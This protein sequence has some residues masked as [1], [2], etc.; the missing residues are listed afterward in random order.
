[1]WNNDYYVAHDCELKQE[2]ELDSG[3]KIFLRLI[4][5]D[6]FMMMSEDDSFRHGDLKKELLYLRLH[7]DKQEEFRKFL[8]GE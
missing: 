3:E 5:F 1:M 2:P 7:P 4:S 8:F 6:E